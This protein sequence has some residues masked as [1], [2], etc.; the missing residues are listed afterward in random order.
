[1]DNN[2]AR[3]GFRSYTTRGTQFFINGKPV[4]LRGEVNNAQFP[5]TGYPP[6]SKAQWL[7][8]F[9]LFKDF[10]L[11]HFRCHTWTP[12]DAAF[13][14]ADEVGI[15]LQ[16]ESPIGGAIT[17]E[18]GRVWRQAECDRILETYGNHPSFVQMTM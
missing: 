14:A 3:F 7:K 18:A 17:N 10:G 5:L 8:I 4:L 11:N 13:A 15:Y 1:V 16:A 12:P 2:S 9:K 6:M